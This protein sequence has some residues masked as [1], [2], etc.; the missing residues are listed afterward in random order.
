M[1]EVKENTVAFSL[2]LDFKRHHF[3][4]VTCM[5]SMSQKPLCYVTAI[6]VNLIDWL[7]SLNSSQLCLRNCSMFDYMF[8]TCPSLRE[9]TSP[10][11]GNYHHR[12]WAAIFEIS[13]LITQSVHSRCLWG[14]VS[15]LRPVFDCRN[16]ANCESFLQC[17]KFEHC[18]F[19]TQQVIG[20]MCV[21]LVWRSVYMNAAAGSYTFCFWASCSAS[22]KPT[23]RR[24]T[25][26]E[27][28]R[29][30]TSKFNQP[31]EKIVHPM[32]NR[33]KKEYTCMYSIFQ[34]AALD[35]T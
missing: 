24:L 27:E 28:A 19:V 7:S 32:M 2:E 34:H 5:A 16:L 30:L 25:T 20:N 10:S 26:S 8:T 9:V 11:V 12:N 22:L 14:S 23:N 21:V 31:V 17:R 3:R 29:Q 18:T 13:A 6:P 1:C 33:K 15:Y 4:A 35:S